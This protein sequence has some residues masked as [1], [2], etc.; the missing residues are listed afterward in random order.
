MLSGLNFDQLTRLLNVTDEEYDLWV[1][2]VAMPDANERHL[3]QVLK[4]VRAIDRGPFGGNLALLLGNGNGESPFELL[5]AG[6]YDR[7][8]TMLG[9]GPGRP[10]RRREG[11]S[12]EEHRRRHG[13]PIPVW[14]LADARHEDIHV[15]LGVFRG[16]EGVEYHADS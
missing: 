8:V 15:S 11:L 10:A 7:V 4:A 6:H 9:V 2:G 16:A 14:V 5:R 1:S 12:A 13:D 3:R